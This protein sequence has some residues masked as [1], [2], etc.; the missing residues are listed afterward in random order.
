MLVCAK[1]KL[2]WKEG[3]K[4]DKEKFEVVVIRFK[5]CPECGYE[6]SEEYTNCFDE[7]W[8]PVCGYGKK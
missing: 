4:M 7:E 1:T 2:R 8:C 3:I 5:I 6:I